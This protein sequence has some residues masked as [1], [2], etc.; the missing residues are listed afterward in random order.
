MKV[1]IDIFLIGF[2]ALGILI[3]LKNGLIKSLVGLVGLIAIVIISY[4][5]KT[6]VV[7]FLI[8]KLPFFGLGGSLS[9]LTSISILFY[10]V[11][12]FGIVFAILYGI[13]NIIL[14]ITKFIDTLLK[15]TI[16][17]I[18]PSK[19]GGAI[20]GFLESWVFLYL[21]LFVL[22]QFS[23]TN[24]WIK[25]SKVSD[26][27]LNNTP[28]V[29]TYLNGAKLASQEIY[30]MIDDYKKDPNKSVDDLNLHIL[31]VEINYK[32]ISKEKAVELMDTG[33]IQLENVSIW[34]AS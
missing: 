11:I 12:A 29:G 6:P 20:I 31:Q 28:I 25:D 21:V 30:K 4:T 2:I 32:L 15:F 24:T 7:N 19:I 5:L 22:A 9:G 13:F 26:L 14:S 8:D 1:L 17:W 34:T 3:G 16:I 27:I 18:I 33:K 10:N 23:V